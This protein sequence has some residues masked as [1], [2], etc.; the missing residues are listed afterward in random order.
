MQA[1]TET[2]RYSGGSGRKSMSSGRRML[3]LS[4]RLDCMEHRPDGWNSGQMRVRMEYHVV[5][6]DVAD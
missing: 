4:G 2:S 3:G 6:M 5:W 1:G